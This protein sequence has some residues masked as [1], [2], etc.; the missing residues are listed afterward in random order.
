MSEVPASVVFVI[1]A[2]PQLETLDERLQRLAGLAFRLPWPLPR[3]RSELYCS[4]LVR[5]VDTLLV[6]VGRGRGALDVAIGERLDALGIG[7][8]I[9][10]LGY[11]T[12]GDYAREEHGIA[13]STAQ[14]RT[15]FARELRSRPLL[16]AAVRAGEVTIRKAEAVLPL[17]RGDAEAFWVERARIASVHSLKEAAKKATG[18][19]AEEEEELVCG[20][21]RLP[22]EARPLV[23]EAEL[24]AG[25]IVG[26][27]SPR[28]ERAVAFCDEFNG[29][30]D[31]AGDGGAADA[32][33]AAPAS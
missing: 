25:K 1:A 16:R 23:E 6:R 30:H 2:W 19:D 29:S 5:S 17:A 20:R 31:P 8:R 12:V 28:W 32:L 11:A 14:K 24:L 27:A 15:R 26:M 21:L 22:P 10:C 3:I 18:E 13:A 9:L 7:D 4:E 33:L